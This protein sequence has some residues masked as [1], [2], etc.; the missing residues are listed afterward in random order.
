[1]ISGQLGTAQMGLAQLGNYNQLLTPG[2]IPPVTPAITANIDSMA[3]EY[4]IIPDFY[5]MMG[6][7]PPK[8]TL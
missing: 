2:S 7:R 8:G 6:L 1:V 5:S 4:V 3:L